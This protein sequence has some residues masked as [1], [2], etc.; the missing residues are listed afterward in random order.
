MSLTIRP[1]FPDVQAIEEAAKRL[2]GWHTQTPLVENAALNKRVGGRVL[3][4]AECLQRTGSFKFRG[5]FNRL[6][7]LD[8]AEKR[9]GVVAFSSGNHGQGVAAAATLLGISATV[10]MPSDAPRLKIERTRSFGADVILYDRF[11]QDREAIARQYA[12][13]RGAI[14]VP[15]FDDPDIITGQGTAGLEMA[16]Q[17]NALGVVPDNFIVCCSGGGLASGCTVALK[18]HFPALEIIIAEPEGY[19]D[20]GRS[21]LEG[22]RVHNDGYPPTLCDALQIQMMGAMPFQILSAAGARG[23]VVNDR[24]VRAAMQCAFQELKL[25]LEPGGAA[26]LAA[27]MAEKARIKDRI[28]LVTLSGGNVDAQTFS[29]CLKAL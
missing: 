5:A 7:Q 16:Q 12:A 19:D 21:L 2:A 17:C 10:I 20:A 1:E 22:Q 11:T 6:A 14:I 23:V 29:A 26:A 25:V 15:P 24:E 18:A 4:K 27:V 13:E 3:M 28:T 8:D 9:S